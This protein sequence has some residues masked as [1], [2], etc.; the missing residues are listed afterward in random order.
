MDLAGLA[1]MDLRSRGGLGAGRT[2]C[3][4]ELAVAAALEPPEP[5]PAAAG[6]GNV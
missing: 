2:C 3:G 5:A 1:C 4:I 6:R